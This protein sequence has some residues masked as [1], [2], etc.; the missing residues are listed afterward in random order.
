MIFA[1]RSQSDLVPPPF[2]PLFFW[3]RFGE[4]AARN[5]PWTYFYFIL[6]VFLNFHHLVQFTSKFLSLSSSSSSSSSSLLLLFSFLL[7]LQ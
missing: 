3:E 6:C 5:W 4:F 1:V 2:D 7:L